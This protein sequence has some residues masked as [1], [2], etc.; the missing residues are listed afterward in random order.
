M[1][2]DGVQFEGRFEPQKSFWRSRKRDR[3]FGD[4]LFE[5]AIKVED[6]MAFIDDGCFVLEEKPKVE[7]VDGGNQRREKRAAKV[8]EFKQVIAHKSIP[9]PRFST[10][11]RL[12]INSIRLPHKRFFRVWKPPKSN[13]LSR[14]RQSLQLAHRNIKVLTVLNRTELK[15]RL[16][17]HLQAQNNAHHSQGAN[18]SEKI[19]IFTSLPPPHNT[20]RSQQRNFKHL[21]AQTSVLEPSSV[22]RNRNSASKRQVRDGAQVAQSSPLQLQKL[23]QLLESDACLKQHIAA[24]F[25]VLQNSIHL[26]QAQK[27][28]V[29]AGQIRRR[30]PTATNANSFLVF[31]R[32][33]HNPLHSCLICGLKI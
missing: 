4:K 19:R 16:G 10:H 20:L 18:H 23:V 21:A 3:P 9:K 8:A 7:S 11:N 15:L 13:M 12:A 31:S 26:L 22:S 5:E 24:L 17:A 30:V 14:T 6:A 29:R 27:I 28:L 2:L 1:R 33:S 32:M 25:V